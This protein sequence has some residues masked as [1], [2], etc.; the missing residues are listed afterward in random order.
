MDILENDAPGTSVTLVAG[1]DLAK[2]PKSHRKLLSPL[3]RDIFRD[4]PGHFQ[5]IAQA[6]PFA[7]MAKWLR[8][9]LKNGGWKL[10]LHRGHVPEWTSV[11][12]LLYGPKVRAATITPSPGPPPATLPA[13][14]QSLYS[15][16]DQV[17]WMRFAYSGGLYDAQTRREQPVFAVDN[18][19]RMPQPTSV[20]AFGSSP[21]GDEL[22]YTED[23]RGGWRGHE[24][25]TVHFLGTIEETINWVFAELCADRCPDWSDNW[26]SAKRAR[27][28]GRGAG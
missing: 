23:G 9:V 11:G 18:P 19:G 25:G 15:L 16:V 28:P 1:D 21:C 4:P 14:L 20:Y 26:R 12:F 24:S 6:C 27:K 2:V 5:R 10:E 8:A 3:L 13:A 7:T 17:S 22:V